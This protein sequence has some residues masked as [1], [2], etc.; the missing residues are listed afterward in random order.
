MNASALDFEE[1]AE[2]LRVTFRFR[3]QRAGVAFGVTWLVFWWSAIVAGV[4]KVRDQLARHQPVP[5]KTWPFLIGFSVIG[6]LVFG[7]MIRRW[8]GWRQVEFSAEGL[9]VREASGS[10]VNETRYAATEILNLRG[11]YSGW[12]ETLLFDYRGKPVGIELPMTDAERELI[13]R[14]P[15]ARQFFL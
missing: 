13:L 2:R 3:R 9:I 5:P 15:A 4:I 11:T 14:H 8:R 7:L 12:R 10:R 1:T 6:I